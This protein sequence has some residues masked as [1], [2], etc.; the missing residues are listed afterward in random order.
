MEYAALQSHFSS[1]TL[2]EIFRDLYLGERT[3]IL[4]LERDGEHKKI[5]FSRGLI[6]FAE[7]SEAHE[8]LGKR[9]LQDKLISAGALDE[10]SDGLADS[11][12]LP[13]ALINRD[14]ISREP[15]NRTIKTIID[16]SIRTLFQW[17]GGAARFKDLPDSELAS[18]TDVLA[19]FE[20]ILQGIF[21]MTDFGPIGEAMRGLDNH[22]RLRNPAPLPV[23]Q[24]TLS[25]SHG[26]I[27]S[28]VNGTTST[29]DVLSILPQHEE[30][31][32]LRF[33]FGLL[34]M[35]V[36]EY[37]PAVGEGPFRVANILRDHADRRALERMQEQTIRQAYAQMRTQNPYEVLGVAP[38]AARQ[39]VEQ[40]YEEAKALFSR[41]RLLPT[42]RDQ[43][44]SELA[45]IE[46][47]LIEAY[48]RLT[49]AETRDAV[50]AAPATGVQ[51]EI[52]VDDLLVRV[53][54]DKTRSKV[55]IEES[56]KVA[57]GY[58]NKAL[59]A[60]R[61]GDFHNAIQYV[62][63]AIS[64]DPKDARLFFLL[65][66]CQVRNPGPRW[67]HQAEQNFTKAT[68]LD[69][70]NATF[71]IQ[72]GRFYK[73]RGLKL[74]ARRQFEEALKLVPEHPEASEELASL[75]S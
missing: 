9:L 39:A 10:A 28:R 54:M 21:T 3:G 69:P 7:S 47:R 43:F 13:Q 15:V 71:W 26:Y 35:G 51:A 66:E 75:G 46:S 72:L 70:W 19:T 52:G 36:L 60:Q 4:E 8:Q 55:A 40:A 56:K 12:A 61:D 11:A 37:H 38:N 62:K 24:L 53:E 18:E 74:R 22:L 49:Q 63:L 20:V 6:H 59:R 5:W 73:K 67:Q 33:L 64:Y 2:A 1:Q 16:S 31:L 58:H 30:A 17:E 25:A 48:L 14:L 42:I 44:R 45:V 34:V 29:A 41:D 57:G 68:E 32:A 27:L 65:A 23:E 50:N